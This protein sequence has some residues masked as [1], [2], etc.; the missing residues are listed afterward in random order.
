MDLVWSLDVGGLALL[1]HAPGL[2]CLR[3]IW[4]E[5]VVTEHPEAAFHA[6]SKRVDSGF[7]APGLNYILLATH[8]GAHI[9]QQGQ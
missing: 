1:R 4:V 2:C 8:L 7:R 3:R 9:L 6:G 5:A